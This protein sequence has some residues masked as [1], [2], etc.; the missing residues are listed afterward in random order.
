MIEAD[1][2]QP[3]AAKSHV[4]MIDF[5]AEA[6]TVQSTI[7]WVKTLSGVQIQHTALL[8]K[9]KD[10]ETTIYED[11]ISPNEGAIAGGTLGALLGSIGMAGLGALLL[12]G[13]GA[14][15]ALGAGGLVGGVLG[16]T[17]GSVTSRLIDFGI[18][19]A[20][21][22]RLARVLHN[23]RVALALQI[24]ANDE[25]LGLIDAHVRALGGEVVRMNG[26]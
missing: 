3:N 26:Q 17:I 12:P 22:E 7:D 14:V 15:L 11:D 25:Q 19:D 1:A 23:D 4:I 18:K 8:A 24:T 13:V 10:G 21:L 16:G 5:P 20:Q 2:S 6:E 9:A